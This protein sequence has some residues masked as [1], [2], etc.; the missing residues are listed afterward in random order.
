MKP[1]CSNKSR[2]SIAIYLSLGQEQWIIKLRGHITG[3]EAIH[4]SLPNASVRSC[5]SG[6]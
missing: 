5:E 6:G 2:L 1:A 3:S 4:V